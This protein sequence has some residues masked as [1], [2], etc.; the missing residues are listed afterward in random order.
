LASRPKIGFA[1]T[2]AFDSSQQIGF[3][4]PILFFAAATRRAHPRAPL[5]A[6][7]LGRAGHFSA[8]FRSF[9]RKFGFAP[10][11]QTTDV[12]DRAGKSGFVLQF[13]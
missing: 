3:D 13:R 10:E 6:E 1:E 7:S 11:S 2:R 9:G 4:L 12:T 5:A 8:F